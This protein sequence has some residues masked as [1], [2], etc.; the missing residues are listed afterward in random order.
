[1]TVPIS[2]Q[3]ASVM[4]HLWFDYLDTIEPIRRSCIGFALSS[5]VPFGTVKDLLQDTRLRGF[6]SNRARPRYPVARTW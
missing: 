6:G 5:R 1:M 2:D 3:T 4:R